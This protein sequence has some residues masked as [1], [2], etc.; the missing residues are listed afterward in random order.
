MCQAASKSEIGRLVKADVWSCDS[1]REWRDVVKDPSEKQAAA[2]RVFAIMCRK[3]SEYE[4]LLPNGQDSVSSPMCPYK[5][6]VVVAG[7]NLQSKTPIPAYE[8]FSEVSSAPAQLNAARTLLAL[9]ALLGWE[10]SVRDAEQA[11]MLRAI[12]E[13]LDLSRHARDAVQSLAI[14]LAADESVRTGTPVKLKEV[15]P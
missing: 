9:S 7:H 6:R 14:C 12:R 11:Y 1:V 4:H 3:S 2:A 13:D 8:L 15:T 10:T 5:G